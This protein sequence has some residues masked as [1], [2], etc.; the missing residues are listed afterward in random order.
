MLFARNSFC[1][2]F[3]NQPWSNLRPHSFHQRLSPGACNHGS[4]LQDSRVKM[5]RKPRLPSRRLV[6]ALAVP[7]FL[8]VCETPE[9]DV[10]LS[11][12]PEQWPVIESAVAAEP[13]VEARIAALLEAMTLEEKLGQMVQAEIRHASP[14]DVR[15]YHLG[16]VLNGG[17]S[18]PNDNPDSTPGAWVAL[19]DAYHRAS[20]DRGGGR[21]GIPVIWGTDAVHGH[22][23]LVGATLF[24][25]NIGLGA[26]NN[27]ELME[28]IGAVTA[29]ETAATGVDWTFAPTLAVARDDR[30]GR[31]YESYSEDPQIVARLGAALIRGLQGGSDQE[32]FG[33]G[34]IVATTKHFLGDGG[35]LDGED[36]GDVPTD[37]RTLRETHGTGYF[38]ALA[39]GA[40]TVMASFSSWRGYKMHGNGYLLTTVLKR[41][42]GFDG[43][44]IGDWEGHGQLLGCSDDAC[45]AA[46]NAGIDMVMVPEDWRSFLANTLEHARSGVIEQSRIDD[47]VSR[48]LRVK[49]RAGLFEKSERDQVSLDWIGHPGHRA[50]A[51]QAARESLVLLKNETGLLPLSASAHVLVTGH[52]AEDLATQTGGWTV[53]WQG[54]GNAPSHYGGAT[55]ILQGIR[56][57]LGAGGGKVTHAPESLP[58]A[59]FDAAV[60]VF[61]EP[62]YAEGAGDRD[63]L[64]YQLYNDQPLKTLERLQR[65]GVPTVTVFL[66]GRPM[67]VNEELDASDAFVAAWL[68]GSEGAAVADLLFADAAGEPVYRFSGKLAF[69]WPRSEAQVRLNRDD[70]LYFPLF[71]FGYGLSY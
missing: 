44:I 9:A 21:T 39:A 51:R 52:A 27:I 60:V 46:I 49:L 38:A 33:P 50:L 4:R 55:T 26:A 66:S 17:G 29:R 36:R 68:P 69:S 43:F 35:T 61:G 22:N 57:A 56:A 30:W 13:A 24:P 14:E 40:Q 41:R 64:L 2:I 65:R 53:T 16:S 59:R 18:W 25:H 71:P 34:R 42:M 5:A 1:S 28:R 63:H 15:S 12:D 37:E 45:A 3:N 7:G 6:F 20:T 10:H 32:R 8:G 48:I 19:A 11:L 58:N 23:N 31:T 67:V 62:P 47:A 54:T 70:D